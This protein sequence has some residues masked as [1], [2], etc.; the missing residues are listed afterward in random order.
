[1]PLAACRADEQ[2]SQRQWRKGSPRRMK[3]GSVR[4]LT[5]AVGTGS[6][7]RSLRET[8][9][10]GAMVIAVS[11]TQ[12]RRW[13]RGR[14]VSE[15]PLPVPSEGGR[16]PNSRPTPCEFEREF[17][18]RNG[19][20]MRFQS[21]GATF[22][23]NLLAGTKFRCYFLNPSTH[24]RSC[25]ATSRFPLLVRVRLQCRAEIRSPFVSRWW[26]DEPN[27]AEEKERQNPAGSET[28]P[29]FG[30]ERRGR[31]TSAGRPKRARWVAASVP[32]GR[33]A[34]MRTEPTR[35]GGAFATGRS[36]PV[37]RGSRS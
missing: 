13:E 28:V 5:E 9:E 32:S 16:C 20:R 1:M 12:A 21:A 2:A 22:L 35:T 36:E 34:R 10:C 6:I 11:A 18:D 33:T 17:Y 31:P 29:E 3:T 7:R 30:S 8:P 19:S 4:F 27:G 26:G 15:H 14:V 25:E 24:D 23:H 37:R